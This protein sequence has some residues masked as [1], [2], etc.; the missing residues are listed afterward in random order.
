MRLGVVDEGN[1]KVPAVVADVAA[2]VKEPTKGNESETTANTQEG[3][4]TEA[5]KGDELV[6]TEKF[7]EKETDVR[8]P[9]VP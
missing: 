1:M 5:A 6:D 2:E 8:S 7:A 3:T 9:E 4:A